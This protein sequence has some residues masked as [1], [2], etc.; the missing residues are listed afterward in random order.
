MQACQWSFD[1][2]GLRD[3]QLTPVSTMPLS[4]RLV[5]SACPN[6]FGTRVH[7][8]LRGPAKRVLV[9]QGHA[10]CLVSARPAQHGV[11]LRSLKLNLNSLLFACQLQQ[12]RVSMPVAVD[13]EAS[14]SDFTST[15]APPRPAPAARSAPALRATVRPPRLQP[16]T[17]R[18]RPSLAVA[19]RA[20]RRRR[21]RGR[22]TSS[23]TRREGSS[24]C[25]PHCTF[26]L[27]FTLSG[28]GPWTRT[29]RQ[30][31]AQPPF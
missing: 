20:P 24:S 10:V 2:P 16:R 27:Y 31:R 26:L 11:V 1:S 19:A 28:R 23:R 15:A 9:Q 3:V 7:T 21:R 25:R 17:S 5:D 12:G 14:S 13:G 6:S 30:P 18:L 29:C 22:R 4:F 8:V